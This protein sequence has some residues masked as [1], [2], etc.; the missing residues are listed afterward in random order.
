MAKHVAHLFGV[1]KEMGSMLG[2]HHVIA[3]DIKSCTYCFY[4]EWETLIVRVLGMAWSKTG[5]IQYH[6]QLGLPD[7]F[8][9]GLAPGCY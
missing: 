8:L 1:G 6:V 2:S 5:V 9:N 7:N 4:V 3:Q